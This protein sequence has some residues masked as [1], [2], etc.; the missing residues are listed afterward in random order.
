MLAF[1]NFLKL[2][3]TEEPEFEDSN[4]KR[5]KAADHNIIQKIWLLP[6][7]NEF[8]NHLPHPKQDNLIKVLLEGVKKWE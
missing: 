1:E 6:I 5:N 8:E 3:I 7:F 2:R 4:D